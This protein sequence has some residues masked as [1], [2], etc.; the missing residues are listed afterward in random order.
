MPEL[1]FDPT[2]NWGTL[3]LNVGFTGGL[4]AE[5]TAA[6]FAKNFVRLTAVAIT[7]YNEAHHIFSQLFER[8]GSK[9]FVLPSV[10]NHLE[11]CIL[12]LR[13][14]LRYAHHREGL[15]LPKGAINSRRVRQAVTNMRDAIEHTDARLQTGRI[16]EHDPIML[17]VKSDRME[18][19][20]VTILY[21]DLA[22]WLHELNQLA[23]QVAEYN[24]GRS[25]T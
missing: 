4:P 3:V 20:G 2:E 10:V 13:R 8:G 25:P 5:R 9:V 23:H 16:G 21:D 24:P 19:G 11:M 22:A 14:A 18:L 12:A 15:R 17:K 6:S 7:Q 1:R